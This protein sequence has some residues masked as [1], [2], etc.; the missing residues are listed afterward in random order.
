VSDVGNEMTDRL[1]SPTSSQSSERLLRGAIMHN[2]YVT[3]GLSYSDSPVEACKI[4]RIPDRASSKTTKIGI[5]R[6][7]STRVGRLRK[8]LLH[9]R[10]AAGSFPVYQNRDPTVRYAAS[11][12]SAKWFVV[13]RALSWWL[14]SLPER[15]RGNRSKIS[16]LIQLRGTSSWRK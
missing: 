6:F 13:A 12:P 3:G 15:P 11:C 14:W 5:C 10:C 8:T 9:T 4:A 1:S 16:L 2:R 7:Q